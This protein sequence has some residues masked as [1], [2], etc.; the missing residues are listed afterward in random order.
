LQLLQRRKNRVGKRLD[1]KTHNSLMT[2][3]QAK[4]C[5]CI[6]RTSSAHPSSS[7]LM[8]RVSQRNSGFLAQ[9]SASRI[10]MLSSSV[11]VALLATTSNF[12]SVSASRIVARQTNATA[13]VSLPFFREKHQ[14]HAFISTH[15]L[16]NYV[17]CGNLLQFF[18]VV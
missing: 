3:E 6:R 11:A 16:I 17:A 5:T 7:L 13:G 10:E 12:A 18:E 15:P 4:I 1:G 14:S 2:E 8:V 9:S